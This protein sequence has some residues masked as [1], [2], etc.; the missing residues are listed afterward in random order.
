[1]A[2]CL[3][4][5]WLASGVRQLANW[6]PVALEGFLRRKRLLLEF[7]LMSILLAYI[8]PGTGALLL[9]VLVAIVMAIGVVFRSVF[10]SPFYAIAKLLKNRE[11]HS[12]TDES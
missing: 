4:H 8:D 3:A 7:Y 1:M 5:P 12:P 10:I 6:E 9:Q 11:S 2:V